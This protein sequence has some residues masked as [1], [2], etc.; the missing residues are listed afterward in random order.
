MYIHTGTLLIL[1]H[2]SCLCRLYTAYN[3]LS[4]GTIHVK[5]AHWDS[6]K[7]RPPTNY[8]YD[9]SRLISDFDLSRSLKGIHVFDGAIGLS[10]CDFLLIFIGII[11][12]NVA[13]LRDI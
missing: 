4:T 10:I 7:R 13:V 2:S 6:A 5:K 12:P 9:K 11:W 3:G 1:G 8:L